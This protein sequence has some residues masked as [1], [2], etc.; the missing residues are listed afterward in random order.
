M[1]AVGPMWADEAVVQHL[2]GPTVEERHRG[3]DVAAD[4]HHSQTPAAVDVA[5]VQ[6]RDSAV[7]GG[8]AMVPP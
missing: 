7:S 5:D 6:I 2:F 8:S 1:V 3:R 4:R